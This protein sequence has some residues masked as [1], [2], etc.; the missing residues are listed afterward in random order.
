M[1][2]RDH[3]SPGRIGF[4]GLGIMGRPMASNLIEAGFDV[5]VWNRSDGPGGELEKQGAE[6]AADPASLARASDLIVTMLS[7]DDAVREVY[8]GPEGLIA[9]AS[10]GSLL[11]D[12]STISPGLSR[13]L[14]AAGAE[15]GIGVIDA[16]VSGGDV[17]AAAGT[18]S[19]MAGGSSADIER[20]RPVFDVLGSS[21][22]HAG[23]AGAG[24]VTKACNQVVVAVTF[25]AVSEALVLGSKQGVKPAVI[26][27]ALAGGM[28]GSRVI[29]VRRR[30]FVERDFT[31][32]FKVDLHHKDL[33]IALGAGGESGAPLPLAAAV[34]QMLRQLRAAGFGEEDD[35]A[36]LRVAEAAASH[37]T[38]ES[39]QD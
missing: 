33:E 23:P 32:G 4:A 12:M 28:A 20:A 2:A 16:P 17:G 25:A 21:V 10:S 34:Q 13:E 18:L 3:H 39:P 37:R 24:Q 36:L 15:R 9:Q 35:S 29:E 6:V 5:S 38:D 7:D 8:L 14:A 11:I 30:N 26:L 22:V 27:D 31:P 1:T 19:I